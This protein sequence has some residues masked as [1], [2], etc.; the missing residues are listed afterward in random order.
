MTATPFTIAARVVALAVVLALA[1]A[2]GVIVGNAIQGRADTNL[3]YPAGWQ[4]GA[5]VPRSITAQ[6]AFSLDAV[7]A[8]QA[9][10]GDA[11]AP[12]Y[13]DY[14]IRHLA[15]GDGERSA[16]GQLAKPTLR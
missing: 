5:G 6:A 14:G 10:R 11:T 7:A 3:G 8:I 15:E 4:G 9:A 16:R 13:A 2:L 12:D 1:A